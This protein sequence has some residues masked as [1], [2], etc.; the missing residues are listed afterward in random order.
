MAKSRLAQLRKAGL[1]Q[2]A[3]KRLPSAK[4]AQRKATRAKNFIGRL[5]RPGTGTTI[6][7]QERLNKFLGVKGKQGQKNREFIAR[8]QKKVLA[9]KALRG[10]EKT[11][12]QRITGLSAKRVTGARVTGENKVGKAIRSGFK[13]AGVKVRAGRKTNIFNI[14]VGKSTIALATGSG[15]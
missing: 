14:R 6:K 8:I 5:R 11:K 4:T 15:G 7:P 1:V 9:G 13:S 3:V 12:F 2:K 10:G